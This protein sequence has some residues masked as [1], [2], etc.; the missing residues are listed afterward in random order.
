VG[1]AS[2][3]CDLVVDEGCGYFL[4]DKLRASWIIKFFKVNLDCK[5]NSP[6]V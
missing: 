6:V 4:H 5:N 3:G 1:F 2:V